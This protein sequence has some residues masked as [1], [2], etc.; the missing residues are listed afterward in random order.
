M[1]AW[2]TGPS[3]IPER[4]YVRARRVIT[5][6]LIHGPRK[7][8]LGIGAGRAPLFR[9]VFFELRTLCNSR[10][11]FCAAAVQSESRPDAT[12]PFELYARVI[13]EL[14]RIDYCGQ[15]AYHVNNEPLLVPDLDRFV[16]HARRSD[17]GPA[18]AAVR[19]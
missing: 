16:A 13:D 9:T 8:Q 3:R 10:C 15:I 1:A 5:A 4:V 11:S 17:R 7:R 6:W 19:C 2:R 14:A 18:P 12:M